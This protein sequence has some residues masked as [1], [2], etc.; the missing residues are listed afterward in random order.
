MKVP[1]EIIDALKTAIDKYQPYGSLMQ[2]EITILSKDNPL[3][4]NTWS[5]GNQFYGW[6]KNEQ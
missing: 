4:G 6:D 1:E 3:K 2:A 5:L